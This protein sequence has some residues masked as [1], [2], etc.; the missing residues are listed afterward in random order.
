T[1]LADLDH[2]VV[3]NK[4]IDKQGS[5]VESFSGGDLRLAR[6]SEPMKKSPVASKLATYTTSDKLKRIE[7][8][9]FTGFICGIL[10]IIILFGF[11]DYYWFL[12]FLFSFIALVFGA[13]GL[14]RINK[15]PDLF[16]GKAFAIASLIIGT[17]F[18]V[19]LLILIL[20]FL[21]WPPHLNLNI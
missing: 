13:I 12:V 18:Y 4:V 10:F 17:T 7:P 14:I 16:W 15:H 3:N 5:G 21:I 6:Y 1:E 20:L 8:F 11:F 19:L 2:N 9:G